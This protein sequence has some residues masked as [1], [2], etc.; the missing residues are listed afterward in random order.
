[1][2]QEKMAEIKLKCL[3][4]ATSMNSSDIEETAKRLFDWVTKAS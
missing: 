3:E 2:T 1:M 4:V